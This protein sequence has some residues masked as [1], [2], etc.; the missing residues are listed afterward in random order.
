MRLGRGDFGTG[1]LAGQYETVRRRFA[2]PGDVVTQLMGKVPLADY[3]AAG[4]AELK[5]A[6]VDVDDP[7][8]TSVRTAS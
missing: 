7:T 6:G 5:R 8:L 4:M 3:L 2:K 1:D